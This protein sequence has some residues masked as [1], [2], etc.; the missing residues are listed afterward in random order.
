[1]R[2]EYLRLFCSNVRGLVC[3]WDAATSFDWNN[4]DVVAF[5][6]IWNIN[7]RDVFFDLLGE[8]IETLGNSKILIGGDFNI[9]LFTE[10]QIIENF[11]LHYG[12]AHKIISVT[13]I[14]SSS[15]IDNF[16]SNVDGVY[17]VSEISIADHQ[18]ITAKVV[19]SS[20]PTQICNKFT[21]IQMKDANYVA[22]NSRFYNLETRGNSTSDKWLNLQNDLRLIVNDC[23]PLK[24]SSHKYLFVMTP[25]LL[26]SRDKK[27]KLL[28]QYKQGR[29]NKE[30]Y[31]AYNKIYR[32]LIKTEQINAFKNKLNEA[33]TNGKKKWKVIKSHLNVER[34]KPVIENIVVDNQ[35]L[36]SK[37]DIA[38][39]FKH[40]FE[41]C[42][43]KLAENLPIGRNT[44]TIMPQGP[45]WSFKN[46]TEIEL[47][48]IIR[49]LKTKNSSGIDGLSNRMLKKEAYRFAVLLKPLINSSIGEGIFP[50]NL[51]TANVIPIF[52]K[53]D[54]NNLNNYR[55][56]SLLPVIS[57]VFEKV[58]NQQITEVIE[59]GF[60]DDNQFGF[61][62]GFSTED[63][64]I[65]FVNEI[66][67]E[68]RANNH[69]VTIFVDVSKA[70]DSCDHEIIVNKLKQTGLD[71][72][73]IKLIRSYLYNR[74]QIVTVD[75]I[76]G[77]KFVVN[78]GVG[79]GTILGPTLFKIYIMDLHL[80]TSLFCSKF[81]DDSSFLASARSRDAVMAL[82]NEELIK[83]S[84]WFT[85]NRLTLHPNKS[86]YLVH[87][88]DKLIDLQLNGIN[89]MRSGYG[90]QEES[91][92]FLGLHIDEN[93]DW[94]THIK[95][96]VNKISKGTY[97]LWRHKKIGLPIK[98]LI[99]ES[100]IRC[101]LLYC[102][103][104]WGS[105]SANKLKPLTKALHKSWK[106]IGKFKQHTLNRL[107]EN[108]I[109][110]HEDELRM[111]ESK[112][113]WR[114]EKNKLPNS[115]KPL[116]EEKA[117]NLRGRRF[118]IP[119]GAKPD[120]L[121]YRLNKRAEIDISTIS[122]AKTKKSMS[123]NL[124]KSVLRSYSF[125]CRRRGCFICSRRV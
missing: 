46:T 119:R 91:V 7:D 118:A 49:N 35:T 18:A 95:Q 41:T 40:H 4:Y 21:Y 84:K 93:L 44:A 38:K 20:T 96:V 71:E 6:E 29:I 112:V 13:R 72:L 87:S 123:N 27:N 107:Q 108:C 104:V 56:I 22:F 10:L 86:R 31:L 83:I 8:Y 122:L 30:V 111:Q 39:A 121:V 34:S 102:L 55:P 57:K 67:K 11:G 16:L 113:I 59:P 9:N 43:E 42:A 89:I 28:K 5:N 109:L 100:F 79:Q 32:K 64:A 24:T 77:G 33:G 60:I 80:H 62:Q 74:T 23:F 114:W 105:A 65:K 82:A 66:Q 115:L 76:E 52:K 101:H 90:L 94:S 68:L 92:K 1:M 17:E 15:C 54:T 106:Y 25:G 63:A 2:E 70:F 97:L 78:I 88:R 75:G 47:L 85:D 103:T 3:N 48:K 53:D 37:H 125:V 36:T 12:V 120:S 73:G 117:D 58:L 69:V 98:K 81:A 110:K 14:L 116:I 26:K 45:T 50:E 61:R 51:K 19:V 124:K 99:Y